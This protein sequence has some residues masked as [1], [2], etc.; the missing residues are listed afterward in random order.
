[1]QGGV[2]SLGVGGLHLRAVVL[3]TWKCSFM[4]AMEILWGLGASGGAFACL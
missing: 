4:A 3:H 1:M 2:G